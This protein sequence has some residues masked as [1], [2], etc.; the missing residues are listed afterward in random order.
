MKVNRVLKNKGNLSMQPKDK[1]DKFPAANKTPTE[2]INEVMK[3]ISK[4]PAYQSH[5]S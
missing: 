5:D 2:K 4:F 1:R 3:F